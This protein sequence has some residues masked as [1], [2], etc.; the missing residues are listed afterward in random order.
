MSD[1]MK[2]LDPIANEL[3]GEDMDELEGDRSGSYWNRDNFVSSDGIHRALVKAFQA[4]YQQC[5]EDDPSQ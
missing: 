1:M 2:K 5:L 3:T 4:G